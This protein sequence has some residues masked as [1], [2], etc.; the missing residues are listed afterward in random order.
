MWVSLKQISNYDNHDDAVDAQ[1]TDSVYSVCVCV[2]MNLRYLYR[3]E[4]GITI[5]NVTVIH[6]LSPS[7]VVPSLKCRWKPCICPMS[8]HDHQ[9]YLKHRQHYLK[10]SLELNTLFIYYIGSIIFII[11]FSFVFM[12][13]NF[14]LLHSS[15]NFR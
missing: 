12:Y 4:G 11:I 7:Q 2:C 8:R 1:N 3:A 9:R 14:I 15:I 6:S 13:C 10:N 5:E